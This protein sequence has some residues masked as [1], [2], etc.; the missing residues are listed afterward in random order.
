MF[1]VQD[2]VRITEKV[3]V[4]GPAKYRQIDAKVIFANDIFITVEKKAKEGKKYN[5]SFMINDIRNNIVRV[6]KI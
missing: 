6:A 1:N 4:K 3:Q 5:T 2:K